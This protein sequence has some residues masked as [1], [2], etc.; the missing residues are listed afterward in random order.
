MIERGRLTSLELAKL[1]GISVQNASVRLRELAKLRLIHMV[2]ESRP[3]GGVQ[4]RAVSLVSLKR[5]S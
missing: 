1:L 3:V 5:P 2:Q 4:Y